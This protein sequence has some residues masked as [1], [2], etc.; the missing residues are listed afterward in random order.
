MERHEFPPQPPLRPFL[1][2]SP[3]HNLSNSRTSL[4]ESRLDNVYD[5]YAICNHSG[6][7]TRGHYTAFCKNPV[8]GC[9]YNYDDT[10]VQPVSEEHLVTSGAYLLFYVRQSLL[11]P[12]PVSSSE[13]SQSSSSSS[14]WLY[15]MPPFKLDLNDYKEELAQLQRQVSPSEGHPDFA[16]EAKPRSRLNSTNSAL[17]APPNY[18]SSVAS[19][20]VSPPSSAADVDSVISPETSS[21]MNGHASFP[22]QEIRTDARSAASLPPYRLPGRQFSNGT[23]RSYLTP[24]SYSHALAYSSRGPGARHDS[25]RLGRGGDQQTGDDTDGALR[26]G[27][28]FQSRHQDAHKSHSNTTFQAYDGMRPRHFQAPVI[29]TRSIP[30]FPTQ[31]EIAMTPNRYSQ[32]P[33]M[34]PPL[35]RNKNSASNGHIAITIGTRFT[36]PSLVH[37]HPESCV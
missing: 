5:L 31:D 11:S 19:S 33:F 17:S 22:G 6:S 27:Y 36:A 30:N 34:T 13:S 23:P 2:P 32:E 15:H 26:R 37:S 20:R 21:V 8:D 9:W 25:L 24:P 16:G 4:D 12:S 3:L 29:P 14:H 35:N 18:G 28:S 7:L 1:P 10:T